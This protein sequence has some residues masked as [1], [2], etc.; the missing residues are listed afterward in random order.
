MTKVLNEPSQPIFQ[1][2]DMIAYYDAQLNKKLE[3]TNDIT[4]RIEMLVE[5]AGLGHRDTEKEHAKRAKGLKA[6]N[7]LKAKEIKDAHMSPTGTA[8]NV[9][10]A[11]AGIAVGAYGVSA[12]LPANAAKAAN[13]LSFAQV[14][15][16]TTTS[17]NG[18][19]DIFNKRTS[20]EL[21]I[22]Q[23]EGKNLE[24]KKGS[25]DSAKHTT[26]EARQR[27]AQLLEQIRNYRK[28]TFKGIVD[29]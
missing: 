1:K 15:G 19:A 3:C 16:N 11:V 6:Q 29:R 10:S 4:S 7:D 17:V 14:G 26:V 13:M 18:V 23:H 12:M 24:D 20:G 8:I 25:S 27:H 21:S 2:H 9:L 28:D 22:K 5:K